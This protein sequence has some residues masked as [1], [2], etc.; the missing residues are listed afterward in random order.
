LPETLLAISH[1]NSQEQVPAELAAEAVSLHLNDVDVR[2]ALEMLSR[3]HGLSILIAPGVTGKVTAN[4]EGLPCD[5]ALNAIL[6]LC[7]L[8]ACREGG[9]IYVYTRAEYPHE[10]LRVQVFPLDFCSSQ[11]VL[12]VV[13]NLLSAAGQAMATE[14]DA[15][16]NRKTREAI[17][18]TDMPSV[19][20]RV[21]EFIGQVDMPPPQVMIE[22][23]VLQINLGDDL[24]HGINYKN[25]LDIATNS[26]LELDVT[27]FVDPSAS[28]AV[29]ARVDSKNVDALLHFLKVNTDA[30]TLAS[31]RV[32][33]VNG[34]KARIQAGEQIPYKVITVT[35][36]SAIEEV[37]FLD[38]GVVLEVTPRIS[39]CGRVLMRVKPEVSDGTFNPETKLPGEETREL[40]SDVLLED[41]QGVVIGGLIQEK[42]STIQ[43]KIPYLG[44]L[45]W[46]GRLFQKR[47]VVKERSEVV[48]TLVPRICM[49]GSP[50][51]ERDC[52]DAERSLTPLLHGALERFPRPWEPSLPDAV[53]QPCH[54]PFWPHRLCP[55]CGIT[56]CGCEKN[57]ASGY[58]PEPDGAYVPYPD[59]PLPV[60]EVS[61]E[62]AAAI[63]ETFRLAAEGPAAMGVSSQHRAPP[64]VAVEPPR[65][66][67]VPPETE[68][69]P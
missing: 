40:E 62:A 41:G 43:T 68:F 51:S 27:G 39:R 25:L 15:A 16:D 2:Q 1:T 11:D 61:A 60:P 66:V 36:T 28:P 31:P 29:F 69:L 45:H 58:V 57:P 44:D 54:L 7:K 34:Q 13:S 48:I 59:T 56:G 42:D 35:E 14:I 18:V 23:H 26:R 21:A 32:M 65:S 22:A 20:L 12:P 38:V 64:P 53:E 3:S 33:V 17:T 5:E 30:K 9:L 6:K 50:P 46:V 49:M 52:I 4:L 8:V 67:P 37:K 10:D 55:S 24:R 63:P 19:L 47:E